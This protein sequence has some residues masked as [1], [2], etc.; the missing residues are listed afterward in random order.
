[1][2]ALSPDERPAASCCPNSILAVKKRDG[3]GLS[4]EELCRMRDKQ[5]SKGSRELGETSTFHTGPGPLLTCRRRCVQQ[6]YGCEEFKRLL[7]LSPN[8]G[9]S[10]LCPVCSCPFTPQPIK[11][12][13]S[14]VQERSQ[15]S[16]PP[17]PHNPL[18][19]FRMDDTERQEVPFAGSGGRLAPSLLGVGADGPGHRLLR[20]GGPSRLEAGLCD[21]RAASEGVPS[22]GILTR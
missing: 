14:G 8:L 2:T 13:L 17:L 19:P 18:R 10:H 5:D 4:S 6:V 20:A 9:S 1:M 7:R 12:D 22:D 15:A 3:P 16:F 11:R 21:V